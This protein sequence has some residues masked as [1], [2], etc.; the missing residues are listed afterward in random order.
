VPD[1]VE[2]LFEPLRRK[3]REANAPLLEKLNVSAADLER[4]ASI[5][6]ERPDLVSPALRRAVAM[7]ALRGATRF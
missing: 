4:L 2:K 1:W 5:C 6:R 7:A 3:A